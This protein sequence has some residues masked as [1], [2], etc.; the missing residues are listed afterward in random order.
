MISSVPGMPSQRPIHSSV[1]AGAAGRRAAVRR[2]PARRS[3]PGRAAPRGGAGGPARHQASSTSGD[4]GRPTQSRQ[5]P[6]ATSWSGAC[7]YCTVPSSKRVSQLP[8]PPERQPDS[9]VDAV[10][11]GKVEQRWRPVRPRSACDR[12][13]GTALRRRRRPARRR[14]GGA[15]QL[16]GGR[17]E[18]LVVDVGDRHAPLGQRRH[19]AS[20][21]SRAVRRRRTGGVHAAACAAAVRRPHALRAGSRAPARRR[22]RRGGCRRRSGAAPGARRPSPR[23]AA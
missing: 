18:S 13:A 22:T 2:A 7:S 16:D 8:Q 4:D 1:E 12:S 9:T 17:T 10:P 3:S 20:A 11:L 21:S 5:W 15:G 14:S 19:Q 23:A 6:G